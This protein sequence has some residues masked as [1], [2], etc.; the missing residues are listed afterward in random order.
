MVADQVADGLETGLDGI[1][2]GTVDVLELTGGGDLAEL[3]GDHGGGAVDQVAPAGDELAVGAAHELCPREVGVR[4]L[5]AGGADEVA[6]GV[7]L[8]AREE[9][10]HVD[11]DAVRGRELLALHREELRGDNLGG[12]VEDAQ[13]T[14]GAT[15]RALAVVAK[16]LGGPDL[17]VEDDVV[18]AHEVVG[19][20]LGVVPPLAPRL[21]VAGAARPL[22]GGA[23]VA[24]DGVEPHVEAL[25]GLVL[26]AG[27]RDAP[28]D[29]ARHRAGTDVLEE[30]LGELDDV[31]APGAG[32][33][34]IVEPGGQGISQGG[35]VEEVVGGLHELGGLTVDARVR[36]NELG[37]V[38]LVTAIVALVA[39]RS[40]GATDRAGALDVAVGQGA[41]GGRGDGGARDLLDH[42]AVVAH[43]GEHVL[44]DAVVVAG[45]RAGEEVVGQAQGHE[46]LDDETVVLVCEFAG[47]HAGAVGGHQD[48]G[49]VFIGTGH[50]EDVMAG[51]SHVPGENVGGDTESRNVANMT[52][53]VG[54]GPCDGGQNTTHSP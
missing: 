16:H 27:D 20:G 30:V 54:V 37:R 24:D 42:V 50:H 32:L 23:Q 3:L 36:V 46:V 33:L 17:G 45:G 9:V 29:V 26:P 51:H 1:Q 6:Q 12:Q 4:G 52:G 48:G 44:D 5:G 10:A 40:F 34:A 19:Q 22:D 8:V 13:V 7:G 31:G 47:A 11:D 39:A 53:A 28:V 41:A 21:G 2:E 43:G 15:L 14:G 25:G 38:H 35:Q 18:L 49:S